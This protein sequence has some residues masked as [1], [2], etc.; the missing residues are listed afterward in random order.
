MSDQLPSER[1]LAVVW[2]NEGSLGLDL[3]ADLLEVF[4]LSIQELD[5]VWNEVGEL[6]REKFLLLAQESGEEYKRIAKTTEA[7]E[8]LGLTHPELHLQCAYF[9]LALRQAALLRA[10]VTRLVHEDYM[11]LSYRAEHSH[12]K[13]RDG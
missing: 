4:D 12:S 8:R 10:R 9:G 5:L 11:P 2:W 3:N 6:S 13:Q 7:V 1:T